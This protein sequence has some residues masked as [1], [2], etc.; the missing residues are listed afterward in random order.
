MRFLKYEGGQFFRPHCDGPYG[1]GKDGRTIESL[2]TAHLYLNDSKAV[3]GDAAE[4]VGGATSFL[5][6]DEK[7]K[8]DIDPKAG[9]VL[10]FQHR[11]LLHSGDDVIKGTKY[12]V[13]T[14]IMY[15]MLP[16]EEQKE[17]GNEDGE[18]A[19]AQN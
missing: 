10:I 4:L 9:R 12:T 11:K 16:E 1:E 17:V 18:A 15:E 14:D 3:A 2:F 7:R 13:R 19:S 6:T 5:S 8:M